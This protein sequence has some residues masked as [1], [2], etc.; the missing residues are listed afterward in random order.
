MV[1]AAAFVALGV[2][3]VVARQPDGPR[4]FLVAGVL[5]A[6]LA[7][8]WFVSSQPRS[9]VALASNVII[10]G[11]LVLA[12]VLVCRSPALMTVRWSARNQSNHLLFAS[13][14][15]IAVIWLSI[16]TAGAVAE[17][18]HVFHSRAR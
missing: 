18:H 10:V 12:A 6:F 14:V 3:H 1:W 4:L 16:V 7:S 15:W 9:T 2:N 13:W 11:A 8:L 5:T 17:L